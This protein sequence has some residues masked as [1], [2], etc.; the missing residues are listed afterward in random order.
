MKYSL[1]PVTLLFILDEILYFVF[2]LQDF[3]EKLEN[4]KD[5]ID[6]LGAQCR[7]LVDNG[8]MSDPEFSL[9][10]VTFSLFIS[11]IFYF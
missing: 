8:Y 6:A 5:G 9:S 1:N 7:E 11:I 2:F 3:A 4:E 10:Q